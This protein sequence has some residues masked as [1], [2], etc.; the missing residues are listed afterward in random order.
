MTLA[1]LAPAGMMRGDVIVKLGL[2]LARVM[3]TPPVVA[4]PVKVTV[5]VAVPGV[6]TVVGVQVMPLSCALGGVTVIAAD[7]E[8][9]FAVAVTVIDVVVVTVAAVAEKVALVAPP[10]TVTEPGTVSAEL[11]SETVTVNPAGG[12]AFESVMVQVLEVPEAIEV[13]EQARL[14]SVAGVETNVIDV[15]LELLLYVAVIVAL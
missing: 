13:G 12:A 9:L 11:L 2:L 15:V 14:E 1:L 5:Q 3:D 8:T 4:G 10:G 7:F 6:V